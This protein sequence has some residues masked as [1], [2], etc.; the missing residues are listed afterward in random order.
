MKLTEGPIGLLSPICSTTVAEDKGQVGLICDRDDYTSCA[1]TGKQA[2][3]QRSCFS[4]QCTQEEVS[5][6]EAYLCTRVRIED[7]GYG[8]YR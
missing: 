8:V 2:D 5:D 1:F 3:D 7:G 4:R 6:M